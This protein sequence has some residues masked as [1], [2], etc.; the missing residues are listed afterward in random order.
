MQPKVPESIIHLYSATSSFILVRVEVDLEPIPGKHTH[1][2]TQFT[3]TN[4][5][6]GI[7][8]GSGRKL[9]NMEETQMN[10]GKQCT[11]TSHRL[12]Q[13]PSSCEA[14]TLPT[15]PSCQSIIHTN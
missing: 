11:A 1:I 10:S 12:S 9:E 15:V 7:F 8:L 2:H 6:T 14:A 3:V 5:P 4:L 13:G